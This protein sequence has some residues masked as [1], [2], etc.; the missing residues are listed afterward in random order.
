MYCTEV[1]EA[2]LNLFKNLLKEKSFNTEKTNLIDQAYLVV[3]FDRL[4]AVISYCTWGIPV[5]NSDLIKIISDFKPNQRQRCVMVARDVI[6]TIDKF[7]IKTGRYFP[8]FVEE[9]SGD[10]QS[11]LPLLEEKKCTVCAKGAMLLSFIRFWDK[12]QFEDIIYSS[13]QLTGK[14]ITNVLKEIFDEHQL[15]LIE[16]SFED[17]G[18]TII[19]SRLL[20]PYEDKI[21]RLFSL[22]YSCPKER[23]LT[24]MRDIAANGGEFKPYNYV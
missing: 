10:I 16:R 15:A 21:C 7:D 5:P 3:D 4:V 14:K 17:W 6:A 22:K 18:N 13:G 24:I 9:C 8:D 23:L 19:D 12:V 11:Q 20:S 1:N 2:S